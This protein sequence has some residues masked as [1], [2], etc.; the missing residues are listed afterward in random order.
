[1]SGSPVRL[2]YSYVKEFK[3]ST[4]ARD[5]ENLMHKYFKKKIFKERYLELTIRPLLK[6]QKNSLAKAM[7]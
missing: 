2:E 4:I 3:N 1:M 7:T 5:K 6:K